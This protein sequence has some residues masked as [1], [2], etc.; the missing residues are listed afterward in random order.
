M[1]CIEQTQDGGYIV[2]GT[3][4]SVNGDVTNHHGTA[5]T[6]DCWII[7]LNSAGTILWQKSYGGTNND[8]ASSI[9]QTTDGGYIFSGYTSSNDGDV[10][11]NHGGFEDGWVVK[12]D[13]TG[14][15]IW[16]KCLG[17]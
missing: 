13:S 3:S 5:S 2:A 15:L 12:T 16:Q 14:T 9:K 7:K 17:G 1:D 6:S 8:Y 11:G 4:N 10:S